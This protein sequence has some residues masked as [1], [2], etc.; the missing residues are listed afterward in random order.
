M[1]DGRQHDRRFLL[2][3]LLSPSPTRTLALRSQTGR[4]RRWQRRGQ[5]RVQLGDAQRRLV[6]PP[7]LPSLLTLSQ[8]TR[9][10][11]FAAGGSVARDEEDLGHLDLEPP[12]D[13]DEAV[14]PSEDVGGSL[15]EGQTGDGRVERL[16]GELDLE[17]QAREGERDRVEARPDLSQRV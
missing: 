17:T 15:E 10:R 1:V 14:R 8:K 12:R 3:L 2:L 6:H 9:A 11:C 7:L 13:E 16:V 5:E 4:R